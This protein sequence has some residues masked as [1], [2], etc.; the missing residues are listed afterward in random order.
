MHSPGLKGKRR[1]YGGDYGVLK[2]HEPVTMRKILE[3]REKCKLCESLG[4]AWP[5]IFAKLL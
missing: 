1:T 4:R 5:G 2:I 3:P